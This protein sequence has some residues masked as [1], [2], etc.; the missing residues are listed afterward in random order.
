MSL[1]CNVYNNSVIM[2]N[3]LVYIPIAICK[4][5]SD[6][7]IIILPAK[8]HKTYL[9]LIMYVAC[10]FFSYLFKLVRQVSNFR[11]HL[12]FLRYNGFDDG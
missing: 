9:L 6:K 3:K 10:I 4:W 2:F 7:H 11:G 1:N 12:R 5:L 8:N